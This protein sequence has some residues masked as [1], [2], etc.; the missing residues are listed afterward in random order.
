M[1][2]KK[3]EEKKV[4]EIPKLVIKKA[5]ITIVGDSPLIVKKFSQKAKEEI[6]QKQEKKA[7]S[8][9]KAIEAFEQ[10][11]E[12]LHWITPQPAVLDEK[13]FDQA[14]KKGAKFGFPATGIK[15]AACSGAFRNKLT[16]DKV[17]LY[18]AFHIT[19]ELCEIKGD[20]RMR[21]DYARNPMTGGAV[22][23]YRPEFT[24]WSITFTLEYN[25]NAY[26]LEQIVNF[27]NIG[28]FSCGIGM[29]RPEKGGDKGRFH[30]K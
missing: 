10:F 18:G 8:E 4:I 14:V 24:N 25:E 27:I 26:S 29:W 12:S 19:E 13:S 15:Q 16:K 23:T 22:M 30:V 1:G 5:K 7:K 21:E 28:G 9:I 20:L 6:A 11:V 17:S 3:V 2:R